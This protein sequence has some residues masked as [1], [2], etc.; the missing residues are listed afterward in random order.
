[1]EDKERK[2][3]ANALSKAKDWK[4]I[5]IEREELK[6]QRKRKKI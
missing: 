3:L 4:E 2:L 6:K 1:L 5:R